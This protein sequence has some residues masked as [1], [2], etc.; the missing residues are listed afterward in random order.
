[1]PRIVINNGDSGLVTRNAINSMTADI[2]AGNI[3]PTVATFA[4]LPAAASHTD[5]IYRVTTSTGVW[6]VNRQ[7]KGLYSS[8]GANWNYIGDYPVTAADLAFVPAAG[9]AAVNVQAAVEEV[10]SDTASLLT[11]K[12]DA[13]AVGSTGITMSTARLL[14][15]STAGTGALEEITLGTNLSFSGTTLNAA[16][17]GGGGS[18]TLSQTVVNIA[19]PP[20]VAYAEVVVASVGVTNT[21]KLF[22]QLLPNDENDADGNADDSVFVVPVAETGQIRFIFTSEGWLVG[23]YTLSYGVSA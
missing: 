19:S 6:L 4:L 10:V 14:G 2:F 9:I 18:V 5:E 3:F 16:G 20:V 23:D 11:G 7:L 12:A 21:S 22:C 15:R 8:D 1:M 13:G 17:G